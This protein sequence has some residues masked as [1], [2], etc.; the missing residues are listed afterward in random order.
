MSLFKKRLTLWWIAA[1]TIGWAVGGE[2]IFSRWRWIGCGV[3][4]A[5]LQWFTL[6]HRF[7]LVPAQTA[8]TCLAWTVGIWAGAVHG[9]LVPDPYC[10]GVS[11]GTL[12]GLVQSGILWRQVSRPALWLPATIVSSILGWVAGT[13]CRLLRV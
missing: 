5:A 13:L 6:Y 9:F 3:I 7:H 10:A 11:G 8:G 12:A 4:V 2:R 1:H